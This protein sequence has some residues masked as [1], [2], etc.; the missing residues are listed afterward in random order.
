MW[1]DTRRNRRTLAA[2]EDGHPR[3]FALGVLVADSFDNHR[4][5]YGP[6]VAFPPEIMAPARVASG[7]SE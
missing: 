1:S 5:E 7:E 3:R 2:H 6:G 4:P